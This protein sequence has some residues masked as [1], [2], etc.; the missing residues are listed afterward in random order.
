MDSLEQ[1]DHPLVRCHLTTVRN[2]HTDPKEF[3][4]A[5]RQ[6]TFLAGIEA[7]RGLQTDTFEIETPITACAGYEVDQTVG[8]VPIL[9]AGVGMVDAM[10]EL[11]PHAQVWHLGLYR[12]EKTAM[13]VGYYNKLPEGNPVDMA[14]ILD[15]MLATGGSTCMACETLQSWGVQNIKMIS[16]IAAPE[17]IYRVQQEFPDLEIYTCAVDDHLNEHKFIVPGLGDA[18]DRIFNTID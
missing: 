14:I 16:I 18:G 2:K 15:P 17:G 10:L 13:P 12:D 5:I 1:I 4:A 3:R 9:R 7:T 11:V 6:L 8:L